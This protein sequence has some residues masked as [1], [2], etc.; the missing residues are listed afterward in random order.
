MAST[1]A[2]TVR[3]WAS[4]SVWSRTERW[5]PCCFGR[6]RAGPK[7]WAEGVDV[8]SIA[9]GEKR[10]TSRVRGPGRDGRV[11]FLQR[12]RNLRRGRGGD[13][14]SPLRCRGWRDLKVRRR[15]A[16][17]CST[18]GAARAARRAGRTLP[19]A[20]NACPL[21]TRTSAVTGGPLEPAA[22]E[23]P[24]ME[25]SGSARLRQRLQPWPAGLTAQKHSP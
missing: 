5:Q 24:G 12:L 25:G 18:G 4:P 7:G 19:A 20:K 21:S 17:L 3:N 22:R 11:E 2:A 8:R 6:W 23:G 13:A 14:L 10:R 9:V 15:H 1:V 16:R